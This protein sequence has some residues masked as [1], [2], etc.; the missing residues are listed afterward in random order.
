MVSLR[1]SSSPFV[2]AS[3]SVSACDI[4]DWRR[5]LLTQGKEVEENEADSW[6]H[7]SLHAV[8]ERAQRHTRR[9]T[10]DAHVAS[11]DEG[12]ARELRDHTRCTRVQCQ[13]RGRGLEKSNINCKILIFH[14]LLA[15]PLGCGC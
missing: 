4:V 11:L 12:L 1:L 9:G 8:D 14:T 10:K 2:L 7:G 5:S 3:L 6:R 15:I 13:G